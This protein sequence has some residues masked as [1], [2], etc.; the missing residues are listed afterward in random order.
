MTE[1]RFALRR[2]LVGV[3]PIPEELLGR[4]AASHPGCHVINGYGPTETTVCSTLFSVDR[5]R[6]AGSGPVPIGGPIANTQVYVLDSAL[7]PVAPG[8]VGELFI[9]GHGLARGYTGKP[10]LTADRFIPDR[11]SGAAGARLYRT[12]DR[13]RWLEKG[14]L[15]FRGRIDSQFK[16]RG[17]RIEPGEIESTLLQ[18]PGVVK[19]VVLV[20]RD[21]KGQERLVA[22]LVLE[23]DCAA[24]GATLCSFVLRNL[25]AYMTP[26]VFIAIDE[27]PV[28]PNGKVN[29]DALPA[30]DSAEVARFVPPQ[31]TTEEILVA[32]WRDVLGKGHISV[33]ANFFEL[34]GHSLLATQVVS[35]IRAVFTTDLTLWAFFDAGTIRNL[36]T[37]LRAGG[38]TGA[39]TPPPPITRASRDGDIPLSFA[40]LRLWTIHQLTSGGADYDTPVA[41]R[42]SGT[43]DKNALRR[44]FEQLAGRHEILRTSFPVRDGI[45]RQNITSDLPLPME[46]LDFSELTEEE[47][48]GQFRAII[49][50]ELCAGFD[51]AIGPLFRIRLIR[52]SQDYLLIFSLSHIVTDAWSLQL[53]IRE[54]AELYDA[55][56]QGRP[57]QLPELAIQ[58]ADYAVWQRGWLQGDTPTKE[59][60]YWRD[61]LRD[62]ENAEL[63]IDF[64]RSPNARQSRELRVELNAE[65]TAKLEM[66]SR[67]ESVTLFMLLAASIDVLLHRWTG[68]NDI[69]IGT[70]V[71]NRHRVE[72]ENLV[73]F[74]V[75]TLVLRADLS[76]D[77]T[78]RELLARVR[79]TTLDAYAHQ[80][81]PF[82]RIVE[83]LKPDRD[84]SRT[85]LFQ[86]L[87]AFQNIAIPEL[88]L[89]GLTLTPVD[90]GVHASFDLAISLWP[91]PD[92]VTGSFVYD[93]SLFREESIQLLL[94][95]WLN[96]LEAFVG[97]PDQKVSQA[98]FLGDSEKAEILAFSNQVPQAGVAEALLPATSEL[99]PAPGRLRIHDLFAAH[100]E[101]APEAIA[102]EFEGRETT[103]FDLDQQANRVAT[104][105]LRSGVGPETRVGLCME[106]SAELIVGMLAVLKAGGIYVPLDPH[107]P[108]DRLQYMAEDAAVRIILTSSQDVASPSSWSAT[109]VPIDVARQTDGDAASLNAV[110]VTPD[111]GAYII[112]TSGSTGRPKGV[113]VTHSNVVRLFE[114]TRR[115]FQFS[116]R[117]T[118]TLFHSPSFDFSVWEIWGAL[119]YGGRLIV[120]PY[121][122]TRSPE[123]FFEL[124]RKAGATILNQTPSA[125]YNFADTDRAPTPPC[126]L[127]LRKVVFGG[128]S[129]HFAKLRPWFERRGFDSP[130][131]IN[132]YGITETTV[133]VTYFPIE[134]SAVEQE[135][136]MIGRPIPDLQTYV[137]DSNLNLLPVGATG[138]L[139]V[140]GA[141]VARG[142]LGRPDL[143]AARFLPD[144]FATRPGARLYRTGD[145][146]KWLPDRNL[147]Y[148][149]RLD[150]QVKIR[151]Y[152]IELG[153]I[154]AAIRSFDGVKACAVIFPE[155]SSGDRKLVA[156][157]SGEP[158]QDLD[159]VGLRNHLRHT[160]PDYMLPASIVSLDSLPLT[161][162]GKIDRRALPALGG[163]ER[164][165]AADYVPPRT[166]VEEMLAAIWSEILAAPRVGIHDNFFELGGHSLS[167][168]QLA[169]RIRSAFGVEIPI[170]VLFDA[171]SLSGM[172]AALAAAQAES[173]QPD[174]VAELLEELET[175]S[176]DEIDALLKK[177]AAGAE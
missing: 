124:S 55:N 87:F 149:G 77:P 65:L 173:I 163:V 120:V 95:R 90:T 33:E 54:L 123:E 86:V 141:G 1:A 140:G 164:G 119:L 98:R 101:L 112:Y 174:D 110:A 38:H 153:E 19:A 73:G 116:P 102:I 136:S 18:H 16:F 92:G 111:N 84:A 81:F 146:A 97:D 118:W 145:R 154:E 47:R 23:K 85:P 144:P 121:W 12:G 148:C 21:G 59:L 13:V 93:G 91:G 168:I 37:I 117:D 50:T 133:H 29:R 39:D 43:L 170:R 158:G 175:L 115:W 138:E 106:R 15:E 108:S 132:M 169:S 64:P 80:D 32:I 161:H 89:S 125:F 103:Y 129:L 78:F 172:T 99:V 83:E 75:N 68:Q 171:P 113:V 131:L 122:V 176:P 130:V 162:Q 157:V 30:P 52:G 128:E 107:L 135:R 147:E 58:Y 94:L 36:A 155:S 28:T 142:Y 35:R 82:E 100:V 143:T 56:I 166:P 156:Y 7:Q 44:S 137:L 167:I 53:L 71:A 42:V 17:Y 66:L 51:L 22:Y 70:P 177:E 8:S 27:L 25:P 79:K 151:G 40:Q 48:E 74:L 104:Y 134:V 105:L 20:R 72:T 150:D 34:G 67:R 5:R 62:L 26:E 76:T 11:W 109:A 3:E 139:Y 165:G 88:R 49:N 6:S 14:L 126:K 31:N 61:Q 60:A 24:T 2:L 57:H 127:P 69:A 152:R 46:E 9:G 10:A 114:S 45:P 159:I 160:L 4:I 96:L 41:L 63:P